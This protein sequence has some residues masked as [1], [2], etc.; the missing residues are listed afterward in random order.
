MSR[1]FL[2]RLGQPGEADEQGAASPI[3]ARTRS[4][5]ALG[6]EL[7]S[8]V[9]DRLD[10]AVVQQLSRDELRRRLDEVVARIVEADQLGLSAAEQKKAVG[11]ILDE[12]L[13]LGPLE[14]LLA[15]PDVSD[16]MVNSHDRI[17]IERGGKLTLSDVRFRDD[18]HLLNTINRIVGR[19][20]RRVDESS[21]M[22]DARLM[23]GSRVNAIIPPLALDG[24]AVSIRRF[25]DDPLRIDDLISFSSLSPQMAKYLRAAVIG[26]CNILVSG[27]T[28]SGKTTLL[29]ILSG[30][31]PPSERIITIEDS[32]E[33]KLQQDHVVRLES[34]PANLEG[35][36]EVSIRDLVVNSLRMRPD[37][38]VIGEIRSVEI[39]D[40][41][42]AMNTGHEGSM[43]T[44]HANTATDAMSRVMTMMAMAG[45]KLGEESMVQLISR[46]VHLVVQAN[47]LPDGSRKITT[48]SEV[49]GAH[50]AEVTLSDVFAFQQ[51]GFDDDGRVLGQH[52]NQYQTIFGERF[53]NAGVDC[54]VPAADR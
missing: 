50:G 11:T 42:Q 40:M 13:G 49:T 52:V 36:G 37:R 10:L 20:G 39:L 32:A 47:R 53:A 21:P 34:R 35:R 3:S 23:D 48:I 25:G 27:G 7:H 28:G 1:S 6:A 18:R 4:L 54:G 14:P 33:L 41:L 16:I 2:D 38:I 12:L 17:Y 31:I 45:T 46:A 44:I 43:A 51:S 15:D 24:P 22:V 19:I 26:K 8:K 29:N 9:L 5:E 30:F